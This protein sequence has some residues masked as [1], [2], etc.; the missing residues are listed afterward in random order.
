MSTNK[1]NL[2]LS[3]GYSYAVEFSAGNIAQFKRE[4]FKAW[5]VF[6]RNRSTVPEMHV[7]TSIDAE[8]ISPYFPKSNNPYR[9]TKLPNA[10]EYGRIWQLIV[11]GALHGDYF[12]SELKNIIRFTNEKEPVDLAL[13]CGGKKNETL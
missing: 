12:E 9:I 3:D 11:T 10:G 2:R 8:Y 7:Q 1:I 6:K 13:V 5:A 4:L